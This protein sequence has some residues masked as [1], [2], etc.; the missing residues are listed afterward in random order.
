MVSDPTSRRRSKPKSEPGQAAKATYHH[1][2]L[3]EALLQAG[4]AL[5][6]SVPADQVSLREIARQAGVSANAVYRHFADK[7]ALLMALA[8]EG[9]RRL[10]ATQVEAREGAKDAIEVMLNAGRAYIHFARD[11]PALFRLMFGRFAK[12]HRTEELAE[13]E[14][15]SIGPLLAAVAARK[16]REETDPRVVNGMVHAW[17]LVH[18][19]SHLLLEGQFAD[20]TDNPE[21]LMW[22]VLVQA[23]QLGG[24][25]SG[26]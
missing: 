23:S 8:A 9:F 11:N 4:L 26:E 15:M 17:A 2:N 1:G 5:L 22:D 12:S 19:L 13:A 20:M 24:K 25:K 21:Q 14:K 3:R 7:D 10:G 6:E 18:G 16:N